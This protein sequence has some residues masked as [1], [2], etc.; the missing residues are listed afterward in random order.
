MARLN[1]KRRR[2]LAAKLARHSVAL[3]LNPAM[4]ADKGQVRSSHKVNVLNYVIPS[5]ARAYSPRPLNMDS[6][7]TKK[8]GPKPKR[9]GDR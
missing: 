6:Q 1:A 8:G 4:V 7:G 2:E 9:W 5:V 3:E